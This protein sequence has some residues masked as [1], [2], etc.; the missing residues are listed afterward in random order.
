MKNSLFFLA[1]RVALGYQI[2]DLTGF[3]F[4]GHR[5]FCSSCPQPTPQPLLSSLGLDYKACPVPRHYSSF[6]QQP[7]R[8][9]MLGG[10]SLIAVVWASIAL[11]SL[12][13]QRGREN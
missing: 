13:Q 3:G 8:V 9:G 1:K 2:Q 7:P 6:C 12:L 5:L 10:G 11:W 4:T